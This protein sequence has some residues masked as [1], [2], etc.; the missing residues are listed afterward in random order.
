MSRSIVR[1]GGRVNR[2][3]FQR[4]DLLEQVAKNAVRRNPVEAC[5]PHG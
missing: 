4:A 2:N 3:A 1:R 5:A